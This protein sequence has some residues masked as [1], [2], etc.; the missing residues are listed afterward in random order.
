MCIILFDYTTNV[1]GNATIHAIK[2]KMY[3]EQI[4]AR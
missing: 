3:R 2:L 1:A 4:I